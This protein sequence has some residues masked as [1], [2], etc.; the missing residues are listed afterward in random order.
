MSRFSAMRD[1]IPWLIES[2]IRIAFDYLQR[3]GEMR[4]PG[5]ASR[6]LL[7]EVD[8]MVL[9]GE[10]RKIMLA[11]RAIERYRSRYRLSLISS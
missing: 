8:L 6:F 2:S 11:N 10:H 1:P 3:S 5:E 7:R 4:D 9:N